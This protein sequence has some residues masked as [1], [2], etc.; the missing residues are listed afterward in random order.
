MKVYCN[1]FLKIVCL[2]KYYFKIT[3]L[4]SDLLEVFKSNFKRTLNSIFT[5]CYQIILSEIESEFILHG[6]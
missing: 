1:L 6:L 4:K 2:R 5:D 3:L